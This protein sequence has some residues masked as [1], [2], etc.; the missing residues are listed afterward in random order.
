MVGWIDG[1]G[2]TAAAG[3]GGRFGFAGVGGF[4]AA[5]VGVAIRVGLGADVSVGAGVAAVADFAVV[6]GISRQQ[7]SNTAEEQKEG[8][9]RNKNSKKATKLHG[10][11]AR[12]QGCT[13]TR[14]QHNNPTIHQ[15]IDVARRNARSD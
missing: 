3:V 1:V 2:A 10:K 9:T 15:P 7:D 6:G 12:L 14:Q 13:T 5:V 4:D 8:T 11:T